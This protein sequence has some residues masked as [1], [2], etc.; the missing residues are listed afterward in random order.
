[1]TYLAALVPRKAD[2]HESQSEDRARHKKYVG[3]M[4]YREVGFTRDVSSTD[5]MINDVLPTRLAGYTLVGC[6]KPPQVAPLASRCPLSR[7][8]H[9]SQSSSAMPPNVRP[10]HPRSRWFTQLLL[11][12]P[13]PASDLP[14]ANP[15][16]ASMSPTPWRRMGA[17]HAIIGRR[18][19]L[20]S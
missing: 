3:R 6:G 18:V 16:C 5:C 10:H 8:S 12:Q 20:A 1:M 15:V 19:F 7:L 17:P 4:L 11:L 9:T 14:A 13:A 2:D